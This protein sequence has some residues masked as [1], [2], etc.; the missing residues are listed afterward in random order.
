MPKSHLLGFPRIGLQREMKKA[1]EAYWAKELDAI[2]LYSIGKQ[3]RLSNWKLQANAGLDFL[4]VGDFSWYDH[5]LDMS[6]LLGVLP[7]R[8]GS[9]GDEI[10]QNTY[11]RMARGRAP[12]GLDIQAC[13][14]TKWFDTNYH[15][16][17]PEFVNN[18]QFR[19]GSRKIFDEVIEAQNIQ[20]TVKPM[21]LGPLTYL[22]LGK[23]KGAPF[24]RLSLL[25]NLIP[26]YQEILTK[27]HALGVEW[28]QFDEPILALD[29]PVEWQKA[30]STTYSL[31]ASVKSSILLATYF[32][33]LDKNID[34]VCK[35][36]VEALH[37]P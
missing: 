1:L 10:D 5:V 3:L 2:G 30:F 34:F 25:H 29:L 32:G 18:Q 31:L 7:E 19:L 6:T 33:G 12:L 26:I 20:S 9:F 36:S 27:L 28:V 22:W 13:E 11:F 15:Y 8:F 24:D 17:V 21:L 14:M 37:I 35:L 4:C 23:C 16:I